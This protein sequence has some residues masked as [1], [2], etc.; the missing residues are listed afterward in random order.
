MEFALVSPVLIAFLFGV[1]QMAWALHSA[2]SVRWALEKDARTVFLTPGTTADQ[3][4]TAMLNDL[5]GLAN[6]QALTVTLAADNSN[7]ASDIIT[8]TSQFT[9]SLWIPGLSTR[10]L[11]FTAK[12]SV[13]AP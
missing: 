5:R 1:F 2:A 12:T 9:Y 8:A 6:P 3:L 7:P 13:P 11:T 10:S 4:K